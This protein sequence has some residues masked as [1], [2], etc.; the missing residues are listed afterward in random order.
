M[1][2]GY[3]KSLLHTLITSIDNPLGSANLERVN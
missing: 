1:L 3:L 2:V